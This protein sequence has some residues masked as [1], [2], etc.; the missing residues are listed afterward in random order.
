VVEVESMRED[1]WTTRSKHERGRA[2]FNALLTNYCLFLLVLAKTWIHTK[3]QSP[4][5]VFGVEMLALTQLSE[6]REQEIFRSYRACGLPYV[7]EISTKFK[8][9]NNCKEKYGR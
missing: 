2:L 1:T 9:N 6:V 3:K 8:T 5:F 7:N 4:E